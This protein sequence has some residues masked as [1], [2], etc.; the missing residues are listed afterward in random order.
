MKS[1]LF[2]PS[3]I[4]KKHFSL[5]KDTYIGQGQ[6]GTITTAIGEKNTAR[7]LLAGDFAPVETIMKVHSRPDSPLGNICLGTLEKI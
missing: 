2:R 6:S 1:Y 5:T 3:E 4:A 7:Y